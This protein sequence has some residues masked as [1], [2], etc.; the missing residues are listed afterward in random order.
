MRYEVGDTITLSFQV[1]DGG[2]LTDATVAV[3]ITLPD[4]TSATTGDPTQVS[5]GLYT[6]AYAPTQV[7][8]HIVRWTATDAVTLAKTDVFNVSSATEPVSIISLDQAREHLN[9]PAGEHAEDEELRRF[10]EAASRVVEDY[11]GEALSRRTVLEDHTVYGSGLVVLDHAPVLSLTSVTS[12]DGETTYD[13]AEVSDSLAGIVAVPVG[14]YG[15]LRITTVVGR[16]EVPENYQLAAAIICGHLWNTQRVQ[17]VGAPGF[18]GEAAP[19]P[20]RG[21]LIPNQAAELLGGRSPNRP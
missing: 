12:S 19:T 20:G 13:T 3:A 1:V 10:V 7:G 6:L 4:G 5:T 15:D 2:T 9:I 8:R 16:T 11:T 18:G 17:S 21:Y 14:L